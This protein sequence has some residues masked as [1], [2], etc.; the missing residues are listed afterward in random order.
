MAEISHDRKVELVEQYENV[1]SVDIDE[2]RKNGVPT[3]EEALSFGVKEKLPEEEVVEEFGEEELIPSEVDGIQTDVVEE[4]ESTAPPNVDNEQIPEKGKSRKKKWRP[5]RPGISIGHID[6]TAGTENGVL[7]DKGEFV[8]SNNHVLADCNQADKGDTITQPG[9][10]D[11]PD[12]EDP[13]DYKCGELADYVK[14][15]DGCTVDLA[16]MEPTV[17]YNIKT[18][19]LG[20][21]TGTKEAERG[22][23]I[24]KSGRTSGVTH[25]EVRKP[26]AAVQVR[27]PDPIG[28]IVLK[29]QIISTKM[30]SPGDS[31]SEAR[32]GP[33]GK[34]VTA[35]G[36]AGS[37]RVSV[38]N[39][40]EEVMKES[41][42]C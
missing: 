7:E 39:R 40:V 16:W 37:S 8:Y 10:H 17:D 32:L 12:D 36:F 9:P 33:E 6:I 25:G 13:K 23:K 18:L 38:F 5:I 11:I 19:G 3:G 31:G 28:V 2:K 4:G 14:V 41:E 26:H 22:D 21:P 42:M 24:V 30:L 35:L 1:V 15:E 27:Y 34:L 29:N 20:K